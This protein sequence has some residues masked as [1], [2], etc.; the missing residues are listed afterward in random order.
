MSCLTKGHHKDMY[1][2]ILLAGL[3]L[4]ENYALLL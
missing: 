4:V 1:K 3:S 2:I